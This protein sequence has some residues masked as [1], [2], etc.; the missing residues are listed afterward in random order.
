M[1]EPLTLLEGVEDERE[2]IRSIPSLKA[3]RQAQ[4][5]PWR[6]FQES[7]EALVLA[8]T[9]TLIARIETTADPLV[10]W[11]IHLELGRRKIPPAFRYPKN[12][13]TDQARFVTWLADVHWHTRRN[14]ATKEV[15]KSWKRLFAIADDSWHT[16]ARSVYVFAWGCSRKPGYYAARLALEDEHRLDLMTMKTSRQVTRQ[17]QLYQASEMHH[18]IASHATANAGRLSKDRR[19]TDTTRDRYRIWKTYLIADKSPTRTAAMF[20]AIYG[21]NMTRQKVQKQMA[22]ITQAWKEYGPEKEEK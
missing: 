4:K 7:V 5:A 15:H 3:A 1:H 20:T 18:A 9:P 8:D 13:S 12:D 21:E 17:R 10:L 11:A 14:P 19:A 16:T 22:A 2:V 6:A